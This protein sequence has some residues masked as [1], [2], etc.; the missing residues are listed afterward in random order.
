M[1][2][3]LSAE[4]KWAGTNSGLCTVVFIFNLTCC[5]IFINSGVSTSAHGP[6]NNVAKCNQLAMPIC[7]F[8][9]G[10]LP[11]LV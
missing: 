3:M 9:H 4:I 1:P 11:C 8:R 7:K 10:P 6:C 2:S 5:I